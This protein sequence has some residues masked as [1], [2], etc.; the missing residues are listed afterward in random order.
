[1]TDA[2]QPLSFMRMIFLQ[3][4]DDETVEKCL[5]SELKTLSLLIMDGM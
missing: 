1:M 3:T 2:Q 5:G 4:L